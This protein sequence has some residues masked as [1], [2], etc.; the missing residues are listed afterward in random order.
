MELSRQAAYMEAK[1]WPV[2]SQDLASELRVQRE[3][4]QFEEVRGR[5][6][7]GVGG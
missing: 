2:L 7:A 4:D 5:G 3:D 1:G 6:V